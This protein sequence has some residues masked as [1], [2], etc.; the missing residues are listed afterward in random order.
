MTLTPTIIRRNHL[1]GISDAQSSIAYRA[2]MMDVPIPNT[3]GE[4]AA[5]QTER[6]GL[7][8]RCEL[9]LQPDAITLGE[10]RSARL[11][12]GPWVGKDSSR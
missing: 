2:D 9:R 1:L 11:G 4:P 12:L 3:D 10:W 7:L 6:G 5:L 8:G